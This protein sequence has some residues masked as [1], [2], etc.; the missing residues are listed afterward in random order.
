MNPGQW[1]EFGALGLLALVL[2][3]AGKVGVPLLKSLVASITGLRDEVASF[4]QQQERFGNLLTI[5]L[6]RE[7]GEERAM[8]LVEKE[9]HEREGNQQGLGKAAGGPR[10]P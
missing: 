1:L 10:S 6:V 8:Q 3:G 2:A 5:L 7:F 4:R 9:H